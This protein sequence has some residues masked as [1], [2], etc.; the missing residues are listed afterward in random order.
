MII[1]VHTTLIIRV[2]KCLSI[3]YSFYKIFSNHFFSFTI[4]QKYTPILQELLFKEI[5]LINDISFFSIIS[6][7]EFDEMGGSVD[8]IVEVLGV[9]QNQTVLGSRNESQTN[10]VIVPDVIIRNH[11]EAHKSVSQ[12][13]L[14]LLIVI[15]AESG[16]IGTGILVVLTPFVTLLGNLVGCQRA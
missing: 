2:L 8:F 4:I 3:K 15:V 9:S 12:E 13:H 6:S 7:S 5:F 11:E 10:K 16:W 14:D 1:Y